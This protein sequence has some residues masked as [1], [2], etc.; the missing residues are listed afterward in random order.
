MRKTLKMQGGGYK[1][2]NIFALSL[3]LSA[4]IAYSVSSAS[5]S[6][7]QTGLEFS[8]EPNNPR[9]SEGAFLLTHLRAVKAPLKL[10]YAT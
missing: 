5:S 10:F 1:R 3:A 8:L 4:A 9:N 7:F 2:V 6:V